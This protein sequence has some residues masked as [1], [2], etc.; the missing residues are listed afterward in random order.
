MDAYTITSES[1]CLIDNG[2]LPALLLPNLTLT[3]RVHDHKGKP[4]SDRHVRCR[5]GWTCDL[6]QVPGATD[7]S[8]Y[9]Y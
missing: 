4:L 2:T 9:I 7:L 8:I 3:E 1:L 5:Q 6:L